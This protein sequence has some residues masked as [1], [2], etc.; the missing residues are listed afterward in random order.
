METTAA[1]FGLFIFADGERSVR[2]PLKAVDARFEITGDAAQVAIEQ[3]FEFSGP[4]P[5]DVIYVF[6]LPGDASVHRC[7]MRIGDRVVSAM[8]K[9]TDE[10]R[11]EF[12]KAKAA[13]H[14]A[15]LVETVR[16]NLFELRLGNVQPGD[17]ISIVLSYT[18]SLA[19]EGKS[20]RL[21][22]PAC[23]GVRYI[24]GN[25]VGVDGGSDIVPDAGRLNPP[26]ISANDPD[27]ALFFCAGTLRG[28]TDI[29]S[30]SHAL[31]IGVPTADRI[32]VLLR[33]DSEVPD[34]SLV[35]NWTTTAAPMACISKEDAGYLLCSVQAPDDMPAGRGQRD[36][37]FLLD[38][39]GSMCGENWRALTKAMR[40]VMLEIPATDRIA[41]NLFA[42]GL[43]PLTHGFIPAAGDEAK[44]MAKALFAHHPN[45][46]TEFTDAFR[47]TIDQAR[48]AMRPVIVIITDGQFGDEA[49][50]CELAATCGIEIHT[51]GIDANVNEDVL[52]KIARRT[53][54]TCTLC[55]PDEELQQSMR[56]MIR[57]LLSPALDRLSAGDGWTV[58]GNPPALRGNQSA[59]VPFK[60]TSGADHRATPSHVELEM[61]FADGSQRLVRVP[62]TLTDGRAPVLL[63]AKAEVTAMLDMGKSKEA[64]ALACH[65]NILCEGTSFIAIDTREKVPVATTIMEQPSLNVDEEDMRGCVSLLPSMPSRSQPSAIDYIIGQSNA[66]MSE[67]AGGDYSSE[68]YDGCDAAGTICGA[69]E[70]FAPP[71]FDALIA[72]AQAVTCF[73][74]SGWMRLFTVHLLPL[75][76]R[77]AMFERMLTRLLDQLSD[78]GGMTDARGAGLRLLRDFADFLPTPAAAATLAFCEGGG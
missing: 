35:M 11:I 24:P 57:N 54:G 32:P 25:P 23:P 42:S 18:Q 60:R 46:G 68:S 72:K 71:A 40:T 51:I 43:Q 75:A 76:G 48:G 34:R 6:P 63:A 67:S 21:E 78:T 52:R 5:V 27:A 39:S 20:R 33:D 73:D 41:V 45:G 1:D 31:E 19:G 61:R 7:D 64:V 2:L 12:A 4:N 59:L 56:R 3:I 50:A 29:S 70:S 30:P 36:I 37:L 58:V 66:S 10:A 65:H 22:I 16:A 17:A 8:V 14:R 26:R 62:V 47:Q 38:S 15:A 9:P 69:S 28:A 77:R 74:Q 55:N 53:R 13:G 44:S 49:R